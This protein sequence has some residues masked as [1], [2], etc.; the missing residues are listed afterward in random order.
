MVSWDQLGGPTYSIFGEGNLV[1]RQEQL[2]C[3]KNGHLMGELVIVHLSMHWGHEK[4]IA[5]KATY[6]DVKKDI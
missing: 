1:W 2:N 5:V 6:L 3:L 4:M